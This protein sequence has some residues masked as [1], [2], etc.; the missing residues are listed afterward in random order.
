[1]LWNTDPSSK[2]NRPFGWKKHD[3]TKQGFTVLVHIDNL[4]PRRSGRK[5]FTQDGLALNHHHDNEYTAPASSTFQGRWQ[6]GDPS[7][8]DAWSGEERQTLDENQKSS[9][10]LTSFGESTPRRRNFSMRDESVY[11][12]SPKTFTSDDDPN[13]RTN[14]NENV[15][16]LYEL[17]GEY[18]ADND[19]AAPGFEV[20]QQT[21]MQI[22]ER[23]GIIT[24]YYDNQGGESS[25]KSEQKDQSRRDRHS[26][27]NESFTDVNMSPLTST[28][29][30]AHNLD[31]TP[32]RTGS[33]PAFELIPTKNQTHKDHKQ[34]ELSKTKKACLEVAADAY[35]NLGIEIP[36]VSNN[37]DVRVNCTTNTDAY[38]TSCY[39][40]LAE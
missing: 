23:N 35:K 40:N 26:E 3:T 28:N 8:K 30:N 11:G 18:D 38:C 27:E 15:P 12:D 6:T 37:K 19:E 7:L 4:T 22:S 17:K 14:T 31:Y 1:M 24:F 21:R 34:R 36:D 13:L 2:R 9:S 39:P 25:S 33:N 10:Y 20:Y 32:D 5:V 16:N 29:Q